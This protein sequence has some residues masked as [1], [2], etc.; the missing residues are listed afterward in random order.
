MDC[1]AS[2]FIYISGFFPDGST[3]SIIPTSKRSLIVPYVGFPCECFDAWFSHIL[4]YFSP[5]LLFTLHCVYKPKLN[6]KPLQHS[7]LCSPLYGNGISLF[8][9]FFADFFSFL[10]SSITFSSSIT[11]FSLTFSPNDDDNFA[12]NIDDSIGDNAAD[13]SYELI[14]VITSFID[15]FDNASFASNLYSSAHT[16]IVSIT[17]SFNPSNNILFN[18]D[19]CFILLYLITISYYTF[20]NYYS[21]SFQFFFIYICFYYY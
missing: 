15:I 3:K 13:A 12:D 16:I 14:F 4:Q 1:F 20:L 19:I 7:S 5:F 8:S 17:I 11:S 10:T 6:F 21:F 9:T 2:T 18:S